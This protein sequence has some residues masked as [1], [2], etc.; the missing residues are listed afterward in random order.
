MH[1]TDAARRVCRK[2]TNEASIRVKWRFQLLSAIDTLAAVVEDGLFVAVTHL[3]D[4]VDVVG[5]AD[6][7]EAEGAGRGVNDADVFEVVNFDDTCLLG[8]GNAFLN[9]RF[10]SHTFSLLGIDSL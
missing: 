3:E 10:L 4:D 9:L 7:I 2:Y 5:G 6:E 1:S 8:F